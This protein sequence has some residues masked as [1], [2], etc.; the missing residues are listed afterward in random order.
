M[1]TVIYG[2]QS[3]ALGTY[4]A[5]KTFFP[6]KNISCFLVTEKRNNPVELAGLPVKELH[7]FA[8]NMPQ[9]EKDDT[10]IMIATPETVMDEI[11][12][13]LKTAGFCN[14][15]RIDSRRWAQMQ[16]LAFARQG[17][18][19]P[20]SAF[21]LGVHRPSIQVYRIRFFK[22][23]V[24]RTNPVCPPY[25]IDLQVG[26]AQTD[27]IVAELRDNVADHISERNAD[28]SELTGLYWIWKNRIVIDTK[29]REH[30]YGLVHYRRILELSEDDLLRLRDNDIDVIFPY[31]M[32]YEPDIEEHHKRYLS[33][34]EWKAV[35]QA[36]E[37]LEPDYAEVFE[38][39]LK[40]QHFYNYNIMIARGDVLESYCSWLFPLLFRIEAIYNQNKEK[41]PNRYIGY[42][43]ETLENLYFSYHRKE[44]RI[45]HTGCRFF[46]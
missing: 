40:N 23:K 13:S 12:N 2:A 33:E 35:W 45:A 16:Q 17:D 39:I 42:I 37:E 22:D 19:L 10:E 36:L 27:V 31:P 5:I 29:R 18:Y 44:L 3:I 30:Y 24:L 25:M 41:E 20:L 15:V 46:A 11:E 6:A 21:P 9:E 26:A 7:E 4:K 43:G 14:L 32:P 38:H 28:Y 34:A 1:E 8:R